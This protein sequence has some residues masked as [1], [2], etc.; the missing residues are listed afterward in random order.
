MCAFEEPKRFYVHGDTGTGKTF[1]AYQL[2]KKL[3]Q[4]PYFKTTSGYWENYNGQKIVVL[5]DVTPDSM[6]YL[7]YLLPK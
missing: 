1:Y 7:S 5:D 2:A 4:E 3:G 6:K